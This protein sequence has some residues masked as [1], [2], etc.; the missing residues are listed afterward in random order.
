M[1]EL[2]DIYRV[3]WKRGPLLVEDNWY[4]LA[5]VRS[6]ADVAYYLQME[7]PTGE[8]WYDQYTL[9]NDLS[10]PEER[11]FASFSTS[12]C[13]K[14]RS[15]RG[16]ADVDFQFNF[17]PGKERLREFLSD[18][19]KLVSYKRIPNADKN[20]LTQYSRH[21]LL[22]L[23][24]IRDEKGKPTVWHAYRVNS[25]RA[26]LYYTVS[27]WFVSKDTAYRNRIGKANRYA[28]WMD[29]RT[30]RDMGVTCYDWGGWY[31]GTEDQERLRINRFKEEF[32]GKKIANYNGVSYLTWKGKLFRRL[33]DI[34][35]NRYLPFV[36]R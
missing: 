6:A 30:F 1:R 17:D 24:C 35:F 20:R 19:E 11:I 2:S 33:K 18:Y 4:R 13:E 22:A 27:L 23:S 32:R 28:H 12:C 14:I 25:E 8:E 26:C 31:T 34:W 16:R 29:M 3:T 15:I 7:V 5:A 21:H 9:L 10:L 36:H